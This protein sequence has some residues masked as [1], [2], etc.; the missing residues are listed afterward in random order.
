MSLRIACDLDGTLADMDAA[1][2]REAV[3]LFGPNVDLHADPGERL[4]SAEDVEEKAAPAPENVA[5]AAAARAEA[6]A[7][8][9]AAAPDPGK[10]RA[11]TSR[12]LRAL[13]QHVGQIEN[14]WTSLAEIEPG[15]V[16]RL[17]TLATQ[18]R[19]EVI[20]LTQRP[21]SAGETGQVQTQRW[22]QEHGFELPSVMVM[23][24]SRGKVADALALDAVID[25]RP[26][27]CLDVTTDSTARALLIWR[28]RPELLPPGIAR[29]TITTVFTFSEALGK[30]EQLMADRAKRRTLFGRLRG[31]FTRT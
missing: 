31:A 1:L 21:P 10:P 15:A 16:A 13:W 29:T 30:L 7:E 24:G 2:Q 20:F 4:E 3:R 18:Y 12:E 23:Q 25:D 11:L 17:A 28:L 5:E 26:E 9:A 14:F 6:A 19:W 22:L 27:N 8:T